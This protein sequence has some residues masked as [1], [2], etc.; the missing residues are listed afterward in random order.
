VFCCCCWFR[1]TVVGAGTV[2]LFRGSLAGFSLTVV[3]DLFI[4]LVALWLSLCQFCLLISFSDLLRS[5]ALRI[6]ASPLPPC[7]WSWVFLLRVGGG[8]AGPVVATLNFCCCICFGSLELIVCRARVWWPERVLDTCFDLSE[9]VGTWNVPCWRSF[10][11]P[12]LP[13]QILTCH[14]FCY[15]VSRLYAG[16][17][18][19]VRCA[20]V[21]FGCYPLGL[22]L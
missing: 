17:P 19:S 2:V 6:V 9:E 16:S 21:C 8:S 10:H 18:S 5:A 12:C 22:D 7:R 20:S 1:F 13:L 11:S 3:V 14:F 4:M 15:L